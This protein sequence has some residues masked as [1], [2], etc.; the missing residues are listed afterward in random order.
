MPGDLVD[1]FTHSGSLTCR[2]ESGKNINHCLDEHFFFL[3]LTGSFIKN[4][5]HTETVF[6]EGSVVRSWIIWCVLFPGVLL[7]CIRVRVFLYLLLSLCLYRLWCI[8][9]WVWCFMYFKGFKGRALVH[10]CC[11]IASVYCPH[12]YRHK[13]NKITLVLTV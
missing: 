13:L 8:H 2:A 4:W 7:Y 6:E 11:G 12:T 1:P 3:I 5:T 10:K 9:L